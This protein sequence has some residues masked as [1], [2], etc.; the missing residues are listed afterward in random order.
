MRFLLYNIRYGTGANRGK[1]LD[2]YLGRTAHNLEAITEY[3]RATDADI[4]GLLE[5]DGGTYRSGGVNQARYIADRLGHYH[6]YRGKYGDGSF[7]GA[8]PIFKK[9]GNAFI[10][11]DRIHNERFHYFKKGMKRLVIELELKD[12][13]IYLVHLA[14][15]FKTRREQLKE[16]AMQI[17]EN[18]RPLVL[19]GD[20]NPFRGEKELE[21]FLDVTGLKK[22]RK[23]PIFTYPS[24]KPGKQLDYIFHSPEIEVS[25]IMAGNVMYSDHLPLVCEF[26][27]RD[28]QGERVKGG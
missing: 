19:A 16:L 26:A 1:L 5:V 28:A 10:V 23:Q 9:Q 22:A 13:N 2:G 21:W 6:S 18:K 24:W 7:A 25:E 8:L 4:V 11:K 3:I 12:F 20:F 17:N 27:L 14:L 15:G